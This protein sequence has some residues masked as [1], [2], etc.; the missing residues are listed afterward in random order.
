MKGYSQRLTCAHFNEMKT[1]ADIAAHRSTLNINS[2]LGVT[3]DILDF[4]SYDWGFCGTLISLH[5]TSKG[6]TELNVSF[7]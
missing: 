5:F 6:K 7:I 3:S 4:L 2:L 1:A